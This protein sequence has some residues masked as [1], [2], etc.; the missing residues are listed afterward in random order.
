MA[1]EILSSLIK[2]YE[3]KRVSAELDLER[4]KEEL[5][6]K[7]PRLA[8]IEKE[9]SM[10]AI[11]TAKEMLNDKNKDED[12]KNKKEKKKEGDGQEK[13]E[14]IILKKEEEKQD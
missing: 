9:L 1:N 3:Q 5:Y 8:Q 4:R 7:I 13:K 10:H 6:K 14:G 12:E 11:K 2:E